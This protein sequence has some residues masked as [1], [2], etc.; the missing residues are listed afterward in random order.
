MFQRLWLGLGAALGSMLQVL[1]RLLVMVVVMVVVA[2]VVE[3]IMVMVV[4][5]LLLLLLVLLGHSCL[6]SKI[7]DRI[8]FRCFSR[9]TLCESLSGILGQL[10][11]NQHRFFQR[12]RMCYSCFQQP[13]YQ[14]SY[15][16]SQAWDKQHCIS[17]AS[18]T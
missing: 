12:Y 2:V 15:V 18:D 8:I 14:P 17:R 5:L 10:I 6:I 13:G 4:R 7:K 1:V 16:S 3:I 11:K 9:L